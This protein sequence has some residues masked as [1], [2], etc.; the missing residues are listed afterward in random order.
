GGPEH[1]LALLVLELQGHGLR[2]GYSKEVEQ[3]LRIEAD[4]NRGAL[5]LRGQGLARFSEVGTGGGEVE[6]A[7]AQAEAHGAAP[8]GRKEAHAP[9]GRGQ[10]LAL[11]GDDLV[12][13][14]GDDLLEGRELPFDH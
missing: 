2:P 7:R 10:A 6:L 4:L 13:G 12:A 3:V 14:E 1:P 5:V 11:Q 9:D 8:L